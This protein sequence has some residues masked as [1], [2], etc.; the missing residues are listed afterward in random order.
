ML[1]VAVSGAAGR[2]GREVIR[3][4]A[5]ERGLALGAALAR[6]KSDQIGKDAGELA[7]V[8]S[9]QVPL[10]DSLAGAGGKFDVLIDFTV[11]AAALQAVSICSGLNK[12]LV[13]GTTGFDA[14]SRALIREAALKIPILLTSNLSPAGNLLFKASHEAARSLGRDCEVEILEGHHL[15]KL[16]MPSGTT[17]QLGRSV[18]ADVL[19]QDAAEAAVCV[20]R[21]DLDAKYNEKYRAATQGYN[22]E[23]KAEV[24]VLQPPAGEHG[25]NAFSI[26]MVVH[27]VDCPFLCRHTV[28]F[29]I[30]GTEESLASTCEVSRRAVFAQGALRAAKFLNG[31]P[32]R[33]YDMQDALGI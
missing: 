14:E 27:R 19:G 3:A 15:R 4:I 8:G 28:Q 7:K 23:T 13:V 1:R 22:S 12:P 32:A 2:M 21:A 25:G 6:P 26:R 10:E 11:P 31:R 33:L 20:R 16:D 9:L 17:L 30:P 29:S 5:E 18:L 24:Y